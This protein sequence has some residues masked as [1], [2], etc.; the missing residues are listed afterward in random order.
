MKAILMAK[1]MGKQKKTVEMDR[2]KAMA[3]ENMAVTANPR[4]RGQREHAAQKVNILVQ[5]R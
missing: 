4:N 1:V 5:V 3:E 2:V